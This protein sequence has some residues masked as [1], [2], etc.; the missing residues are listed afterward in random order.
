MKELKKSDSYIH[1]YRKLKDR[2]LIY[3]KYKFENKIK[4]F[5]NEKQARTS[6]DRSIRKLDFDAD[7][8]KILVWVKF[9]SIKLKKNHF[10]S[11][12]EIFRQ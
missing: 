4:R 9:Y 10:G 5:I 7:M 1:Y 6:S 11:I 12:A 8:T 2:K 3:V